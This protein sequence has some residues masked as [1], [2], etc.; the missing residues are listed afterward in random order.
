MRL[1]RHLAATIVSILFLGTTMGGIAVSATEAATNSPEAVETLA[2]DDLRA[3]LSEN[4]E[5]KLAVY[6]LVDA[7]NSMEN[8]DPNFD[9]DNIVGESLQR[10]SA[11]G[12]GPAAVSIKYAVGFF[13]TD[14]TQGT[15][16]QEYSAESP[17]SIAELIV[18]QPTSLGTNWIAGITEARSALLG[19]DDS[20]K[21]LVWVTDGAIHMMDANGK[22]DTEL[23]N[24]ALADLCGNRAII[25]GWE[26]RSEKYPNGIFHEMRVAGDTGIT[27][28]GVYLDSREPDANAIE[29]AAQMQV[30]IEAS[31]ASLPG[32]S[33]GTGSVRPGEAH[34]AF[35]RAED[36]TSLAIQFE[37]LAG[38]LLGG[39]PDEVSDDG[40][41]SVG[42]GVARFRLSSVEPLASLVDPNGVQLID[43]SSRVQTFDGMNDIEVSV[44]NPSDYGSWT[45]GNAAAHPRVVVRFGD[46]TISDL[47][48][49]AVISGEEGEESSFTFTLSTEHPDLTSIRDYTFDWNATAT[50]PDGSV[51][52]LADGDESSIVDGTNTV[53]GFVV[54]PNFLDVVVDVEL[55]NM[56]SV[57][58]DLLANVVA[59]R[60]KKMIPPKKYPQ[61]AVVEG[62][63]TS[64][65]IG[66]PGSV[67]L[68]VTGPSESDSGQACFTGDNI[69][70]KLT[71][72]T[73]ISA[74]QFRWAVVDSDNQPLPE[75]CATVQRNE[76][77]IITLTA[78]YADATADA[79]VG[80]LIATIPFTITSVDSNGA[81]GN[82][83]SVELTTVNNKDMGAL[84]LIQA[85]IFVVGFAL[86]LML[87]VYF[88][89]RTARVRLD[90]GANAVM[91]DGT[92]HSRTSSFTFS[93]ANG[94]ETRFTDGNQQG[95]DIL[96]V[97]AISKPQR[98]YSPLGR[99]EMAG[100]FHLL[101]PFAEVW[102]EYTAP[103]G[104]VVLTSVIENDNRNVKDMD[105]A[106]GH[107]VLVGSA[108]RSFKVMLISQTNLQST[109]V[110]D[111]FSIPAQLIIISRPSPADD[112]PFDKERR[113]LLDADFSKE[114]RR[115]K[116][117]MTSA[118]ANQSGPKPAKVNNK[119]SEDPATTMRPETDMYG[120][121]IASSGSARVT[122]SGDFTYDDSDSPNNGSKESSSGFEIK[123]D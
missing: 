29:D 121:L 38:Y 122:G 95:V 44:V 22:G 32:V 72:E 102:F 82:D 118:T 112:A 58:G 91:L 5:P 54:N 40:T 43:D 37:K 56:K 60:A 90:D 17:N 12:T 71:S 66:V 8:S 101:N 35:I 75:G 16:W 67:D 89:A 84:I 120:D 117:A 57:D 79:S 59:R 14:F 19:Q 85:V 24:S 46:L 50:Y 87:L 103:D 42:R 41:F 47:D 69:V 31:S 105:F 78:A 98:T 49:G 21:A 45:A 64:I 34:G 48:L 119:N 2:I 74:A 13:G 77:Q 18:N 61:V 94:S 9:R 27:I 93:T 52:T 73:Y 30:L 81:F 76:K 92:Y 1:L 23:T 113:D 107:K 63:S 62:S 51:E 15:D 115:I 123:Y 99:G 65:D 116:A 10:L 106:L 6:Y 4:T 108:I 104:Y 109:D 70:S 20:C 33:C 111:E 86:P 3:C 80:Q 26:G 36:T 88:R 97:H 39:Y 28:F 25:N 7:S 55:T 11:L 68:L 96:N 83:I 53:D 110:S 114:L 100:R